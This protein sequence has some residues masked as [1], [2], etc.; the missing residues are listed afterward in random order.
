MEGSIKVGYHH[1]TCTV[2][3]GAGLL[4]NS[5]S[6][7]PLMVSVCGECNGHG[8]LVVPNRALQ[9]AAIHAY[10]IADETRQKFIH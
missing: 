4:G 3:C 1:E 7:H 8:I 6:K 5:R 10:T 9:G 2:C